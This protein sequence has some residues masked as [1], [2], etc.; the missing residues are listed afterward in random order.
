MV[1]PVT[2]HLCNGLHRRWLWNTWSP[3]DGAV[4]EGRGHTTCKGPNFTGASGSLLMGLEVLQ[5]GPVPIRSL[6]FGDGCTVAS[7]LM[8]LP[9]HLPYCTSYF[10]HGY[11]NIHAKCNSLK[12][13]YFGSESESRVHHLGEATAEGP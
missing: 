7:C 1:L 3:T 11:S 6:L 2:V 10:P 12:E 9:T 8:L 5:H 13:T 4:T